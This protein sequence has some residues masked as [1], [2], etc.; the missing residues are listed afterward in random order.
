[1]SALTPRGSTRRWRRLR[2][3]VLDRDAH[4]CQ[5]PVDGG[6]AGNGGRVCGAHASHVDHVLPRKHGGS[7][8]PS[9]LRAACSSCNLRRGSSTTPDDAPAAAPTRSQTARAWSW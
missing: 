6:T 8:H 4:R 9:N 2:A 5:V 7:D 3:L 1:V